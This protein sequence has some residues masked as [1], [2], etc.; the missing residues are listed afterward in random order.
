MLRCYQQRSVWLRRCGAT[1]RWVVLDAISDRISADSST[2]VLRLSRSP[3]LWVTRLLQVAYWGFISAHFWS[4][5]P[6][7]ASYTVFRIRLLMPLSRA[8]P[9]LR[10]GGHAV[11]PRQFSRN[12]GS[13]R[14]PLGLVQSG[15]LGHVVRHRLHR[16]VRPGSRPL[17][18]RITVSPRA[19]SVSTVLLLRAGS[20]VYRSFS[21]DRA[22]V[23]RAQPVTDGHRAMGGRRLTRGAELHLLT[24]SMASPSSAC[25]MHWISNPCSLR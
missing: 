9:A 1:R 11:P 7:G 12:P 5:G 25:A 18:L 3:D 22:G 15:A 17:A 16:L 23:L 19:P 10:A 20:A 14:A 13:R 21:L 24:T 4:E 8:R 2:V 6:L